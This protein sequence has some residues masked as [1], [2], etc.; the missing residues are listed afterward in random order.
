M[1]GYF[2][3]LNCRRCALLNRLQPIGFVV[4]DEGRRWVLGGGGGET[5]LGGGGGGGGGGGDVAPGFRQGHGS[6]SQ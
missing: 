2:V 1:F 3:R 6:D 4:S 5:A